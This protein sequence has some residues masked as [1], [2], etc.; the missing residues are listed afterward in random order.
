MKTLAPPHDEYAERVV[1]GSMLD[2]PETRP[3][4]LD[5]LRADDFF[6]QDARRVF[7]AIR[8]LE[9]RGDLMTPPAVVRELRRRG[10]LDENGRLAAFVQKCREDVP[11]SA[12]VDG[13]VRDVREHADRRHLLVQLARTS[14]AAGNGKPLPDVVAELRASL[15]K[16]EGVPGAQHPRGTP[17][18][19]AARGGH[20]GSGPAGPV[21]HLI[22]PLWPADAYG[23]LGAEDK[24]GKTW[25]MLDL[26]ASVASGTPWLNEFDVPNPGPTVMFLGE[27]GERSTIRRLRAIMADRG[28]DLGDI[29][30]LR[31]CHRV[32]R[33]KDRDDLTAIRAELEAHPPRM[34][35]LDPLYLAAAGAKGADLYQMGETLLGIQEIAQE[36]GAALAVSTHWNKTGVGSGAQRFTGVG[37]GA[38]G[39]V[40]GSA[41]VEHRTTEPEGGT[42]VLLRWEFVG[43]EI[44]DLTFRM[45][46]QVRAED[47]RDLSSPLHYR[48]DVT[49]VGDHVGDPL[50]P[51]GR[52]VLTVLPVGGP[53]FTYREIG[54]AVAADGQGP[55]L[56]RTTI[57][58]AL[59]DL[60]PLVDGDQ[61]GTGLPSRW[62]R[63]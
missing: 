28:G 37:P 63:Q 29:T 38:W 11:S 31:L 4:V 43:G 48:V 16:T 24:A 55:P 44:A 20:G 10:T 53:G 32:P 46:R 45:R 49:D 51:A 2:S 30:D 34:V 13:Y 7:E 22:E 17:P 36:A 12:M 15:E 21:G 18:R 39:R 57:Q 3:G 23:V 40:L 50:S 35:G 62:W 26:A 19:P 6:Q 8:E 14:E 60:G 56:K 61:P 59:S 5:Q 41:A 9:G 47:P 58:R 42:S 54:D 27:G 1:I 52:R 25:V 33:L